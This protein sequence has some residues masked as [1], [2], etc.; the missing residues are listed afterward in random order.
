[1]KSARRSQMSRPDVF[2]WLVG[3]VPRSGDPAE[4]YSVVTVSYGSI[5]EI[6]FRNLPT[7]RHPP[8]DLPLVVA[9]VAHNH[10]DHLC[11]GHS[12]KF[13]PANTVPCLRR[14][15]FDPTGQGRPLTLETC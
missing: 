5:T 8:D 13:P 6:G 9:V 11:D 7:S 4:A 10:G 1:M 14:Q 2:R 12:A 3:H 15:P